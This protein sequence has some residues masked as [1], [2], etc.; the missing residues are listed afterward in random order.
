MN[1]RN[2]QHGGPTDRALAERAQKGQ[3]IRS[4][5]ATAHAVRSRKPPKAKAPPANSVVT[6]SSAY[7]EPEARNAMIA[8]AAYFRSAHRGFEPGHEAD[9]WFAAESEIDAALARGD[10]SLCGD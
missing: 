8:E 6:R 2:S 5:K 9:D 4:G 7:V 1:T 3:D 10:L